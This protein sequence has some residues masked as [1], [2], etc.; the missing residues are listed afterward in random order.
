M[1]QTFY[2]IREREPD[3]STIAEALADQSASYESFL[4]RTLQAALFFT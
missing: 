3:A 2:P 1:L 4:W